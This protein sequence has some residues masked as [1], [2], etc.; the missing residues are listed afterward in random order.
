MNAIKKWKITGSHVE[1]CTWCS[2]SQKTKGNVAEF[3]SP[4]DN[5]NFLLRVD[6]RICSRRSKLNTPILVI[7]D[8]AN[9]DT[10]QMVLMRDRSIV[11]EQPP[12]PLMLN[13]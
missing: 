12:F 1:R 8:L 6:L 5:T 10:S 2:R 3:E 11:V 9:L 7:K 13:N 4:A